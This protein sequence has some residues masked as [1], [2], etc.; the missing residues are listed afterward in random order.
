MWLAGLAVRY[1]GGPGR[2]RGI[3]EGPLCKSTAHTKA[4]RPVMARPTSR[5]LIS[6]VPS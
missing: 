5:V 2:A 6:R 3:G 1:W 4:L